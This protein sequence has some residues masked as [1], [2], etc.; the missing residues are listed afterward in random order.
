ML[1]LTVA[2][3]CQKMRQVSKRKI[4]LRVNFRIE[5]QAW[6]VVAKG[7]HSATHI[8]ANIYALLSLENIGSTTLHLRVQR[9]VY[10]F[11]A[12]IESATRKGALSLKAIK[13][14]AIAIKITS[15]AG[16]EVVW[17]LH[18]THFAMRLRCAQIATY[19]W[20]P[21]MLHIRTTLQLISYICHRRTAKMLQNN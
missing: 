15:I 21:H 3:L 17:Q 19:V 2:K 11:N 4:M 10:E 18:L 9:K 7:L 14:I 1:A 6:S 8:R 16:V 20:W 5:L 12:K 13:K